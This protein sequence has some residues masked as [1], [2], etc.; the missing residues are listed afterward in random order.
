MAFVDLDDIEEPQK[1]VIEALYVEDVQPK[2]KFQGKWISL[3]ENTAE[4]SDS[5]IDMIIR[6]KTL[7]FLNS[8]IDKDKMGM[9][10][11]LNPRALY[12]TGFFVD[13]RKRVWRREVYTLLDFMGDVGGLNDALQTICFTLTSLVVSRLISINFLSSLF[14]VNS[15]DP[16]DEA[17]NGLRPRHHL[18]LNLFKNPFLVCCPIQCLKR[19]KK[20]RRHAILLKKTDAKVE[21]YLDLEYLIRD[22]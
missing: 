20:H 18:N 9:I 8:R 11:A 15:G 6:P 21:K 10:R 1:S 13:T 5:I 12:L 22:L 2:G 3:I 4:L 17:A 16:P 19:L 14:T 7:T